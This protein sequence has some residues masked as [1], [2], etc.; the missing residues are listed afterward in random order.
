VRES[1]MGP[2]GVSVDL[3]LLLFIKL[4]FL[5]DKKFAHLDRG[6][7]DSNLLLSEVD[8]GLAFT[9][10]VGVPPHSETALKDKQMR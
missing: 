1:L 5:L 2:P 6:G 9:F 10:E 7:P 8:L 3:V 4:G